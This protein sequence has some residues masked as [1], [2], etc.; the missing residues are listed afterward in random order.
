MDKTGF[1]IGLAFNTKV[2]ILK[3]RIINFKTVNGNREW[4][5]QVDAINIHRQTILLFIIFKGRQ[6]INSLWETA[7]E[8]IGDC[9]IGIIENG[10]LNEE[11]GLKWLKY[12]KQ[13]TQRIEVWEASKIN[14]PDIEHHKY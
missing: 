3:R 7:E 8:I 6:H 2:V 9:S 5:T 13:H 1:A 4:V 14:S 12:F 11:M 10:W